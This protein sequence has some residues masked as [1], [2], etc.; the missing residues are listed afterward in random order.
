MNF[1]KITKDTKSIGMH[2]IHEM[3]SL[4]PRQDNKIGTM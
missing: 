3:R 1:T 4:K 2:H